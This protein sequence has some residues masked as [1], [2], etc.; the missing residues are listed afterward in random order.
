MDQTLLE[1]V[2]PVFNT[3][4]MTYHAFHYGVLDEKG[5]AGRVDLLIRGK[6]LPQL[7]M[8]SR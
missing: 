5:I 7:R 3:A 1:R 8:R 6:L 4:K 2:N